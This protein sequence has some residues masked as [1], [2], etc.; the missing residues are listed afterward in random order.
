MK[1][2][3]T[4]AIGLDT[5]SVP[6]VWSDE[7][8]E[9]AI[10]FKPGRWGCVMAVFATVASKGRVGAFIRE[11]YGCWGADHPWLRVLHEWNSA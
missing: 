1:S 8:P 5:H 2:K 9:G 3:I 6:L 4:E 7:L 10:S 11:T